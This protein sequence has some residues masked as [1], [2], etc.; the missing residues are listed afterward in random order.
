VISFFS[1]K[2]PDLLLHQIHR[3]E[4]FSGRTNL[5]QNDQFIQ[6][7]S[8]KMNQNDT[9]E[10]H[11]HIWKTPTFKKMIAQESWVVISG[12]VKVIFYDIDNS[13]L[14]E[15][16]IGPGDASFTFQGGHNYVALEENTLVYEYKTGPYNGI[17][18]DKRHI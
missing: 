10:P 16:I 7:A 4:D 14:A 8:L 9:F 1:K 15:E 5:C 6:C 11:H 18:N 17:Q 3:V 13:I 2:N 12:M